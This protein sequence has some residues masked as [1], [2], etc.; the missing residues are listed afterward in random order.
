MLWY[1]V[2]KESNTV[3]KKNEIDLYL[4]TKKVFKKQIYI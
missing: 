4:L 1:R 2:L 3:A